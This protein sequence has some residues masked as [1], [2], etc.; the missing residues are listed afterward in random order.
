VRLPPLRDALFRAVVLLGLIVLAV[1]FSLH[2]DDQGPSYQHEGGSEQRTEQVGP[3]K[4]FAAKT[5]EDPTAFFTATLAFLTFSLA[6]VGVAQVYYLN[7]SDRTARVSAEAAREAADV[8]RLAL[9]SAETPYLVPVVRPY[10]KGVDPDP[11]SPAND[12]LVSL[13]FENCGRS[14]ATVLEIR[15]ETLGSDRT[16]DPACFPP[17]QINTR[18]SYILPQGR[19]S[20]PVWFN[21]GRFG[22]W[23]PSDH[24]QV[25]WING[26]V[27]YA[28]VFGNQFLTGFCYYRNGWGHHWNAQG[29][30]EHNFRRKLTGDDLAT[31]MT[32]DRG[33]PRVHIF[34]EG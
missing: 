14:P 7:R 11:P 19:E 1:G 18:H 32:R 26:H 33:E 8:A 15:Y 17:A 12:P 28:D 5:L 34:P 13:R 9:E 2:R 22:G 20:N 24:Y 6:C 27:R 16:P 25:A 30:P 4:S 10:E 29:G 31:A 3:P 21:V 23:L